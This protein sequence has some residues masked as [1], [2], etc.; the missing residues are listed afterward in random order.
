M[1]A[2]LIASQVNLYRQQF[3]E[4][5]DSPEGTFNQSE[6]IQHLRF[7]HLLSSLSLENSSLHDVGCGICDLYHY[8]SL[9]HSTLHYSGTEIVPEMV[10]VAR[11]KYPELTLSI[12]DILTDH[13]P[14]SY[15]YVVQS[16]VFNLPGD[17]DHSSWR[18]FTRSF[19]SKM[20]DLSTKAISFNF[21]NAQSAQ[22]MHPDMY[23]EHP[24]EILEYCLSNLSRF[25]VINQSYPLY[26]F[27]VTV[28]KDSF[29]KSQI[30]DSSLS[31]FF[32][33]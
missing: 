13:I 5:G 2:P 14:E 18:L 23:Y 16:G 30:S 29:V 11:N 1:T 28:F 26:E 32:S 17:Q 31:R 15:D 27:T 9:H 4:H 12:R 10:D 8:I 24:S 33:E 21:L 20:F 19:I 22:Y 3:L 6:S 7:F 25:S